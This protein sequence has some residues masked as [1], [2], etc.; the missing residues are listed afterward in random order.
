MAAEPLE[1]ACDGFS[2]TPMQWT[3]RS[4]PEGG[5]ILEADGFAMR[6]AIGRG[7]VK[8]DKHEGDG[9]TPVGRWPLREGFY[10][11]DRMPVPETRLKMTAL[12]PAAGWCDAPGDA[13]YN[14]P[15]RSP[16]PASHEQLWRSDAIYDVIVVMG[17]N[18]DPVVDGRG[19][20][21]FLHLSRSD[22]SPTAGC[23]AV[24]LEDMMKLLALAGPETAII[25]EDG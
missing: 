9:A 14:K 6:C 4:W 11:P 5:H 15:V 23:V 18:D 10:R 20:A 13:N 21:I 24:Q 3:V 7:G 2:I 19:S 1:L 8:R 16:Y 22:Y 25:V 17:Y 12:D